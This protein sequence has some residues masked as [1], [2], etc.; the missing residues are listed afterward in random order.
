MASLSAFRRAAVSDGEWITVGPDEAKFEIK[1]RGFTSLY[2]DTLSNLRHKA[3]A[4]LSRAAIRSGG[5]LV[6]P[7][8]L[9]PSVDDAVQGE[10]LAA[11]C[12]LDVRGLEWPAEDDGPPR[13]VTGQEFRD[14]IQQEEYRDLLVLALQAAIQVTSN[15][16]ADQETAAKNSSTAS[17]GF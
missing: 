11:H 13:P 9:P 12:T 1:S 8:T 2:R 3:A 17:N 10:A 5:T 15:R 16:D 7:D 4:K 14:M 6:T